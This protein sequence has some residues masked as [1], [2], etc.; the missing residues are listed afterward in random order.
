MIRTATSKAGIGDVGPDGETVN[1]LGVS[2]YYNWKPTA[3]SKIAHAEFVPMIWS[4]HFIREKIFAEL[5]QTNSSGHLLG[6]NEP[7]RKDQ[8][9]LSVAEALKQWPRL[10][11]TGFRLGSPAVSLDSK[12]TRWLQ[13]FMRGADKQDRKVDFMCVHWYGDV[14][15]PD[16]VGSLHAALKEI[17]EAYQRPIWLTE[18]GAMDQWFHSTDDRAKIT[19]NF[20]QQAL[21]RLNAF[22]CVERFAWFTSKPIENYVNSALFDPASRQL[23]SLGKAYR[24]CA[25]TFPRSDR[26][27]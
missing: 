19:A 17:H 8:A 14:T 23:T 3:F 20:L 27:N 13:R 16:A 15:Q 22:P 7:E 4:P 1:R 24:E 11:Q 26:K 21:P 10:E 2:W 9:H 5:Q 6:F 12:G 25:V 18:F